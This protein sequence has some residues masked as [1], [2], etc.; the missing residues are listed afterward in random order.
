[1]E[2]IQVRNVRLVSL[3]VIAV[4]QVIKSLQREVVASVAVNCDYQNDVKEIRFSIDVHL[5]SG[6]ALFRIRTIYY[7]D[8]ISEA[9][10]DQQLTEYMADLLKERLEG[11]LSLVTVEV[12]C[13]EVN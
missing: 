5:P 6:E 2:S 3:D 12:G 1:M 11:I 8:L 10:S 7:F 13:I 4:R 9:V